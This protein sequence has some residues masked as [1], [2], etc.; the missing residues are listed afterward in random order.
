MIDTGTGI[1]VKTSHRETDGKPALKWDAV[2]SAVFYE[3]Y[4]SVRE[5]GSYAKV[6]TTKGYTYTHAS[7]V[8]GKIYYYKV[9]A[10]LSDETEVCSEIVRNCCRVADDITIEITVGHRETDGKPTLKWVSV[11]GAVFYEVYRSVS[12]SGAYVK[13][14]VTA[15]NSYAHASAKEDK[16]YYYMLKAVMCDGSEICSEVMHNSCL[17]A[18]DEIE[19]PEVTDI[20]CTPDGR[21]VLQWNVVNGAESYEVYRSDSRNESY[22]KVFTTTGTSYTHV[23][24]EKGHVYYYKV[25]VILKNGTQLYSE[26]VS[27]KNIDI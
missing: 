23:S 21:P 7:A 14:F 25:K 8:E 3:V 20:S 1:K 2:D 24:A 22:Q 12:A 4:R 11:R 6:F 9:K 27:S 26:T 10:V 18:E 15:G 17:K 19:M 16:K 5:N 13:V